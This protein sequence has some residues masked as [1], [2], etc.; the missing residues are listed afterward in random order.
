MSQFPSVPCPFCKRGKTVSMVA[1]T[2]LNGSPSFRCIFCN[3]R[4]V[5]TNP[6]YAPSDMIKEYWKLVNEE[7]LSEQRNQRS[8]K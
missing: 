7:R 6:S 1:G 2:P 5:I 3:C 8:N 4:I